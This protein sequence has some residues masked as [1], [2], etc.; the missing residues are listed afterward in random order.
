M[1][2]YNSY[3]TSADVLVFVLGN[4]HASPDPILIDKLASISYSEGITAGRVYGIGN[5]L[6]GFSNLGNNIVAGTLAVRFIHQDYMLNAVNAALGLPYGTKEKDADIDEGMYSLQQLNQ[7]TPNQMRKEKERRSAAIRTSK[8][9]IS[10]IPNYFDLKIAF[11]NGNAYHEDNTKTITLQDVRITQ[12]RL[13][14]GVGESG[15]VNIEYNFMA[16]AVK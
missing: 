10:N 2:E 4:R 15:P 9:R 16:R 13:S 11:N 7:M 6:F 12:S 8:S 14:A 5:P 3:Y 1:S